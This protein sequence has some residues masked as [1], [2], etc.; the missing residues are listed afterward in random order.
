MYAIVFLKMYYKITTGFLSENTIVVAEGEMLLDGI[1]Q[2]SI[3]FPLNVNLSCNGLTS[4]I[5]YY[6]PCQ[7]VYSCFH[8]AGF[9]DTRM[10]SFHKRVLTT[11]HYQGRVCAGD[12]FIALIT[13]WRSVP[14]TLT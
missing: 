4:N 2:V 6:F 1:F 7:E 8:F 9:W 12:V 14:C 3:E 13:A 10:W 11:N 5:S